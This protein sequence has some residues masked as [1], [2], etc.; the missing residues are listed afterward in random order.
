VTTYV[1][2]LRGINLGPRRRVSMPELREAL[3]SAG[4]EDVRTHLQ[5][6]NV[7]LATDEVPAV[8]LEAELEELIAGRLGVETPVLVRTHQELAAVVVRDPLG[9]VADDPKRYQVTFLS[10]ALADDVAEALR[11]AD[12]GDERLAVD[13]REIYVWHANGIQ[14]SPASKLLTDKRLGVTATARNWDTVTALVE[15]ASG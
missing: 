7:V 4:Y 9:D 11:S 10:E 8:Q 12:L 2:L 6:G 15:L 3:T 13:G 5:S 14:R 1:A